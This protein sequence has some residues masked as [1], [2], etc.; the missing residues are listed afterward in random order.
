MGGAHL[1]YG[2]SDTTVGEKPGL[3]PDVSVLGAFWTSV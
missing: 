3:G 1:L 2:Q